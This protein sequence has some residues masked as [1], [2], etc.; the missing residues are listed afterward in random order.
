MKQEKKVINT[1]ITE[2]IF[3]NEVVHQNNKRIKLEVIMEELQDKIDELGL[4]VS[5]IKKS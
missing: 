3:F 5:F 2:D 4:P 1:S